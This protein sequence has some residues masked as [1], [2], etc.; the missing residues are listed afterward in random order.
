MSRNLN[1]QMQAQHLLDRALAAL[2]AGIPEQATADLDECLRI[3]P[4]NLCARLA[5]ARAALAVNLPRKALSELDDAHLYD[6][7]RTSQPEV[8]MLRALTLVRCDLDDVARRELERLVERFPDDI[9]P[10]RMLAELCIRNGLLDEAAEQ[11]RHV[12][13]LEPTNATARRTLA[14]LIQE[15]DP[16]TSIN[17]LLKDE[18]T[19]SNPVTQL[20]AARLCHEVGRLR[21]AEEIYDKLLADRPDDPIVWLETGKLADATGADSLATSRLKRAV[22]LTDKGKDVA[23]AALALSHMHAGRL[24]EAGNCWWRAARCGPDSPNAWAGLLVCAF[25]CD[26]TTLADRAGRM[27]DR[28]WSKSER[29]A[30]IADLWPHAAGAIVIR[31]NT[32]DHAHLTIQADS[33][34]NDLLAGAVQTLKS[35]AQSKPERADTHY[36]LAACCEAL[37]D[38]EAA[39]RSIRAAL[40]INPTYAAAA[41]LA[42]RLQ[43]A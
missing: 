23:L 36:H 7:G 42:K 33:P 27:L 1:N 35:Q 30:A 5:Q 18:T 16:Q 8:A 26:R 2:D 3:E 4:G 39:S 24:K 15:S 22:A 29:R 19:A 14:G 10:R 17:M 6:P 9:R 32:P 40:Q 25:A 20:L 41:D 12:V 28:H 31:Q 43:A 11:M 37:E 13:R 21:D 34:L 38:V